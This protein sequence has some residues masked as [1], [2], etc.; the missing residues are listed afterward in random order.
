[1]TDYEYYNWNALINKDACTKMTSDIDDVIAQGRFWHNSPP[2]QT[3]INIFGIGTEHWNNL[4]MSFIWSCFAYM[5]QE[6]QI[7]SVKSWGYKTN[8]D[9]QEDRQSYWHQHIRPDCSVVSGVFYLDIPTDADLKTSGTEFAPDGPES[10]K[11]IFAEARIGNWIIFPGKAWHRP[12]IL[13]EK[14]WRYIVAA[15]MEI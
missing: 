10:D 11:T 9:T 8:V 1:M 14:K 5:K 2:Y 3:N 15:D 4:K 12:G 13:T 6:R 7:K